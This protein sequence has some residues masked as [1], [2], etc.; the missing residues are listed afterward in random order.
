[1]VKP[2]VS[3]MAINLYC[4]VRQV[5]K[6]LLG[7]Q[8]VILPVPLLSQLLGYIR[9]PILLLTVVHLYLLCEG[10]GFTEQRPARPKTEMKEVQ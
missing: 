7:L 3:P 8:Q 4:F 9:I 1:M 5:I 6:R 2:L 10:L